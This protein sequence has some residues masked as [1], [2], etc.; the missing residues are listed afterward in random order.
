MDDHVA[1]VAGAMRRLA[2]ANEIGNENV[3]GQV[4]D[5]VVDEQFLAAEYVRIAPVLAE[6]RT[7]R[8]TYFKT[9]VEDVAAFNRILHRLFT[10]PEGA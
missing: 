1:K 7:H 9:D 4:W 6:L 5:R 8:D 10:P 2:E 3:Y